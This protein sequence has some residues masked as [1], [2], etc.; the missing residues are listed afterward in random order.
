MIDAKKTSIMIDEEDI[1]I[2]KAILI[3]I[4]MLCDGGLQ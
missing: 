4:E 1:R 3:V 2:Q